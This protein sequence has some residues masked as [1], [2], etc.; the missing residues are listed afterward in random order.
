MCDIHV[1]SVS[2]SRQANW[3]WPRE[4]RRDRK[5]GLWAGCPGGGVH[6]GALASPH[7]QGQGPDEQRKLGWPWL[8]GCFTDWEHP[9]PK[10]RVPLDISSIH[11]LQ[12][13]RQYK[14]IWVRCARAMMTVK[15]RRPWDPVFLEQFLS[16]PRSLV[17][18]TCE[19]SFFVKFWIQFFSAAAFESER[20]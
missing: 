9:P 19:P 3:I 13:Q 4:E 17:H 16:L 5:Q 2:T 18:L 20:M 1:V 7:L 11:S 15:R 12:V 10:R 8:A 6:N 14:T